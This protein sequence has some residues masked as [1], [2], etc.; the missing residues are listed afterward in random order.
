MKT[1]ILRNMAA[2]QSEGSVLIV[3]VM[4][5]VILTLIGIAATTTSNLESRISL[6]DLLAKKAF[7]AS[8]SGLNVTAEIL[9]KCLEK[10]STEAHE[11]GIHVGY[12]KP[13][14]SPDPGDTKG[15]GIHTEAMGK[16]EYDDP[17]KD[18][19]MKINDIEAKIDFQTL[20]PEVEEGGGSEFPGGG[21][22]SAPSS[23]FHYYELDATGMG[24]Q[25]ANYRIIAGCKIQGE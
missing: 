16:G 19:D 8:E 4:M 14:G 3:A 20:G 9:H 7:Y 6:N 21:A 25:G 5:L 10:G 11:Q 23:T 17:E 15:V 13:D 1:R 18:I 22:Q 24:P 12:L 2:K